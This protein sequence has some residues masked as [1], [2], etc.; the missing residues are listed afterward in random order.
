VQF[1][2]LPW[3]LATQPNVVDDPGGSCAFQVSL[4]TV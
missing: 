3:P 1:A 2:G 4:V